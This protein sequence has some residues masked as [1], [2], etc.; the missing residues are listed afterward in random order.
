MVRKMSKSKPLLIKLL[1]PRQQMDRFK[2]AVERITPLPVKERLRR[3]LTFSEETTLTDLNA[4]ALDTLA[5]NLRALGALSARPSLVQPPGGLWNSDAVLDLE[6]LQRA[7]KTGVRQVLAQ[8]LG[9]R[10]KLPSPRR[11]YLESGYDPIA[12][13]HHFRTGWFGDE[14][15]HDAIVEGVWGLFVACGW[16][17]RACAECRKPFIAVRRQEYCSPGCSQRTRN[18]RKKDRKALTRGRSTRRG[19]ARST[20]ADATTL[21]TPADCS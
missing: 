9:G 18:Q 21:L 13:R 14:H 17:L 5:W 10:W 20:A 8:P 19:R 16:A 1:P 6:W 4:E 11:G 15:G 3:V 2:A 7:I 12:K